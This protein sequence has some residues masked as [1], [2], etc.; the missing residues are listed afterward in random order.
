[1]TPEPNMTSRHYDRDRDAY[2]SY[3]AAFA[4]YIPDPSVRDY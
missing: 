4:E 1:M 2:E 3:L